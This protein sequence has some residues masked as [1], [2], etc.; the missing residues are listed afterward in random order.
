MSRYVVVVDMIEN[1][2]SNL[3]MVIAGEDEHPEV[4]ESFEDV[5]ELHKVH[6]L[7]DFPWLVVNLDSKEVDDL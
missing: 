4:F 3:A 2:G 1:S 7:R 6:L 5:K